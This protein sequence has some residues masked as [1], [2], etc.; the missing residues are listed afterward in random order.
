MPSIEGVD[1][2]VPPRGYGVHGKSDTGTGVDGS[3]KNIGVAGDGQGDTPTTVGVN[4]TSKY[5]QGVIGR[6]FFGHG[7]QGY[8]NSFRKSGVYGESP[9]GT[10][11]IGASYTGSGLYGYST[12]GFAA[13]L[14]GSVSIIGNL[15]KG[16]GSFKIDHPLDPANKYLLHSFVESPEMKN[17]YDAVALLDK[18]GETEIELPDWF[19][20]LNKDFRSQLIAIGA[21]GPNL[22]IAQEI[23]DTATTINYSSSFKIAGGTS[24]MKVSWQVTGIRKD[25]WANANRIQVEED[26]PDG[27]KG[28]Y[29]YPEL[30][31]QP[32]EKEIAQL[33]FPA[34]ENLLNR[35]NEKEDNL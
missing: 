35:I 19:G 25:P 16:G 13:I 26:K 28:Y 7:V 5:G 33:L 24:D 15:H 22:Y 6:S 20:A 4:G 21:P 17:V 32:R 8:S 14:N 23:L 3:S 1:D 9:Q 12:Y 2:N 29:I 34:K 11:V 10:G 31:G 30:Y 27:E 18:N